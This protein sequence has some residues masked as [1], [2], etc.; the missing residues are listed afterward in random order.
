VRDVVVH[1]F[2]IGDVEDPDLYAAN[3]LQDWESSEPGQ[4]VLDTAVETPFWR[5][6]QN[7]NDFYYHYQIVARLREPDEMFFRLKF[8]TK[9]K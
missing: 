3:P 2:K 4:W 7:I 5:R 1:E 8:G 6:A 9:K